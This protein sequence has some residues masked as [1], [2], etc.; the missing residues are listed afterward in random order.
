[1]AI[2]THMRLISIHLSTNYG[3]SGKTQDL[4]NREIGGVKKINPSIDL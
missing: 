2:F 1:M 4:G 3:Q